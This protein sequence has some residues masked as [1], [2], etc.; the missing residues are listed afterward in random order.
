[1][2]GCQHDSC[3]RYNSYLL[4]PFAERRPRREREVEADDQRQ[5]REHRRHLGRSIPRL[6]LSDIEIAS[7]S[8][9]VPEPPPH[10]KAQSPQLLSAT[11]PSKSSECCLH[12]F[13]LVATLNEQPLV[14]RFPCP[15]CRAPRPRASIFTKQTAVPRHHSVRFANCCGLCRVFR[16]TSTSRERHDGDYY[17]FWFSLLHAAAI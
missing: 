8:V 2:M 9:I 16:R 14:Y 3:V 12:V 11:F 1:M 10:S 6:S 7:A 5:S 15:R 17:F 13:S 4:L